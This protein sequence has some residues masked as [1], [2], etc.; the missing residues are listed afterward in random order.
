M[1]VQD[2]KGFFVINVARGQHGLK[3]VA[4]HFNEKYVEGKFATGSADVII[5]GRDAEGILDTIVREG[6]VS[7]LEHAAYLGKELRKAQECLDSG[8]KYVQDKEE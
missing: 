1:F 6:L 7:R 8:R 5:E 2:P 3:I 4:E